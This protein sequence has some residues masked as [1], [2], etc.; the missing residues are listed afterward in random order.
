[1]QLRTAI[2][3][4]VSRLAAS[5]A[6]VTLLASCG[7][8]DPY[9]GLWDGDM[10]GQRQATAVVLG[11][12]DYYMLY[13]QP[14]KPS[15]MGGLV[16]GTGDFQGATF[17]SADAKDY[18]WEVFG[19]PGKAAPLSAKVSPHQSVTGSAGARS[20]TV[21][22]T[23]DLDDDARIADIAGSHVGTV[24]FTLGARPAVFT[25]TAN[26]QV[27]TSINGCSITGVATPR[28]DTEAFDLVMTFGGY[29]C[30]FPG[31]SFT[32]IAFYQQDSRQLQAAVI[33]KT[34]QQAIG[35]SGIKQ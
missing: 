23:R 28:A 27:S 8:G 22:H 13:S 10:S 18:N 1:M 5:L 15:V 11:D 33:N 35:F 30:V 21:R 12:G 14:G 16:Q 17:T 3:H 9:A 26:G 19:A 7:G 25:V 34:Y 32:G 2:R 4:P 31:V 29:P 24:M 20:F 6:A